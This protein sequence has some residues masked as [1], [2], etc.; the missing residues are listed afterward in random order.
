[1]EELVKLSASEHFVLHM[2]TKAIPARV[3]APEP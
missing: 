1:L 3:N 2:A